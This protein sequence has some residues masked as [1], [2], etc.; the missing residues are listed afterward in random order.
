MSGGLDPF[1]IVDVSSWAPV[2][3]EVRSK[4]VKVW[5]DDPDGNR[6]L[7]TEPLTQP[8]KPNE[9]AIEAFALRLARAAGLRA[10]ESYSCEWEDGGSRL[11]GLVVRSF[12]ERGDQMQDGAGIVKGTIDGYDPADKAGHTI[13]RVRVALKALE[14]RPGAQGLRAAFMDT[15]F[16][17]AWIGNG[18]R[19]PEN[20]GIIRRSGGGV[21]FTPLFDMAACL[22][23]ELV[24]GCLLLD[25]INRTGER[26][27]RYVGDCPSG[28]GN[29]KD[30]IG[31]S[32]VVEQ[33]RRWQGWRERAKE[34]LVRF[35]RLWD[36]PIWRYFDTVPPSWFSDERRILAKELLGHR[37]AWL[38]SKV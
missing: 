14:K 26:L 36:G 32:E 37:L 18:D 27:G 2:G 9:P 1:E 20:W 30:L 31:Q 10:P 15:V 4:R 33:I 17:D 16:F 38:R 19:H 6:W 22:G 24:D 7:R 21:E 35:E 5:V 29:G 11:R 3:P 8:P 12:T 28:F 25:P 34:L 13:A 23:V